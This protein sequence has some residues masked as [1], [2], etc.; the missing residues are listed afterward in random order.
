MSP[1]VDICYLLK[2]TMNAPWTLTTVTQMLCALT[3]KAA[4]HVHATLASREME[5][6]VWVKKYILYYYTQPSIYTCRRGRSDIR[7]KYYGIAF[8]QKVFSCNE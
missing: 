2:M 7:K 5:S 1:I 4:L 6:V 8:L 3:H